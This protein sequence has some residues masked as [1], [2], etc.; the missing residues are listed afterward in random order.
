[1][2]LAARW[3]AGSINRANGDQMKARQPQPQCGVKRGNA[4]RC[5]LDVSIYEPHEA[6]AFLSFFSWM[7]TYALSTFRGG[8]GGGSLVLLC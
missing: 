6:R 4:S 8:R 7:P 3:E 5:L 2:Q 1:M